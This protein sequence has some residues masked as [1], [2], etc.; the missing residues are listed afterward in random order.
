VDASLVA[1]H[2]VTLCNNIAIIWS[3]HARDNVTMIGSKPRVRGSP[4]SGDGERSGGR[5]VSRR[6]FF[7]L[8]GLRWLLVLLNPVGFVLALDGA[9]SAT[10]YFP[11]E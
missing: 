4:A 11:E 1:G 6:L 2:G 7:P 8:G 5:P 9:Y 3:V 10:P